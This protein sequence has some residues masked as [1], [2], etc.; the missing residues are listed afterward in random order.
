MLE[1]WKVAPC[2]AFGNTCV[3]KPAEW[4]PL[5]A[6]KLAEIVQEADLPPGVFNVVH[7]FGETAGAPIVAHP[8]VNVISFTGE[9][10][11]GQTIIRNGAA[12]LKRYLHGVGWQV[13]DDRVCRCRSRPRAGWRDISALLAQW[14]A[15]HRGFALAAAGV[16]LR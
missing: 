5:S 8:D 4:P 2:L 11:T 16:D 15:L 10:S 1:T 13:T 9:T 6:G 7:G 14:R 12:T 3:L